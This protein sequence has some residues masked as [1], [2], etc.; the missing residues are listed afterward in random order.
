V[1]RAHSRACDLYRRLRHQPFGADVDPRDL[2]VY[3][4][5]ESPASGG[6]HSCG[7]YSYEAGGSQSATT[8]GPVHC[9]QTFQGKS[10]VQVTVYDGP[11]SR[12]M[13]MKP[14][15]DA[16]ADRWALAPRTDNQRCTLICHYSGVRHERWARTPSSEKR[17]FRDRAAGRRQ[18]MFSTTPPRSN[19]AWRNVPVTPRQPGT[20][21]CR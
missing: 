15:Q 2:I 13:A 9:P 16:A 7:T 18:G 21:G 10:F 4:G 11:P 14:R 20:D 8:G 19:V 5:S 17:Q 12:Q 3:S 6:G 1:R